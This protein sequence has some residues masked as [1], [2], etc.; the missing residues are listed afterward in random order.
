MKV[1]IVT[2]G[3]YFYPQRKG[4][5]GWTYYTETDV[6]IDGLQVTET[7]RFTTLDEAKQFFRPTKLT[8]AWP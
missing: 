4:W 8:V 6:C 3:H 2:D 5:F 7:I 1:R